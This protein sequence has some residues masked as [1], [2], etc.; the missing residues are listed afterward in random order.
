LNR[1]RHDRREAPW[2]CG[3][4]VD[5]MWTKPCEPNPSTKR[6]KR[7]VFKRIY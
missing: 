4:G 3:L 6:L 2:S 5:G 7:R 1:S